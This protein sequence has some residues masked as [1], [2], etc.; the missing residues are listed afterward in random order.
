MN[1][2]PTYTLNR[3]EITLHVP[4]IEETADWYEEVLGW[5]GHFDI[6]D[7][8]GH[9]LFGSVVRGDL[10]ADTGARQ[11]FLG[12]NLSRRARDPEAE[13]TGAGLASA[14]IYVDDVDAV[15]ERVLAAGHEPEAAPEDQP[16]GGRTF[17]LRD[18]NGFLLLFAQ[19]VETPSLEEI[20][21]RVQHEK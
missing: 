14:L 7:E 12:F 20:Q 18:L 17:A 21:R 1:A 6:F 16:W 11:G 5:Q 2:Q 19:Q 8:V 15:Y 10:E 3:I 4:S 9:C 13:T